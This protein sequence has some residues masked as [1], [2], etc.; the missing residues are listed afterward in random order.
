MNRTRRRVR[1]A[2]PVRR[3]QRIV[4]RFLAL[5]VVAMLIGASGAAALVH[6]G[7]GKIGRSA[8]V[9]LVA[10][11][12]APAR[13][14]DDAPAP[15][16]LNVLIVGNDSREGLTRRQIREFG[17]GRADGNRT[18]TLMLLQLEL[19]GSGRGAVLS[20]P[21]DLLV[22]RCDGTRGRIN[23]ASWIGVARTGDGPSCVVSTVHDLTGVDI[24]HY[25]EVSFAGFLNVVDALGGVGLYLDQPIA[26][27]KAHIDLP[28]GCVRLRGRDALGFVRA[29]YVDDDFGRIARQQRFLKE[30]VRE[31]TDVGVLTN[32]SR[33]LR[34]VDAAAASIRTDDALDVKQM[35]TIA[36]GMRRLTAEGLTVHTVPG[37]AAMSGGT[38][39]V[40]QHDRK[41]RRLYAAFRDGSIVRRHDPPRSRTVKVPVLPPVTVSNAT[42]DPAVAEA[43]AELV[44]AGR[45][46]LAEV[47][48]ADAAGLER[49]RILHDPDHADAAARLARLFPG[50]DV[51]EGVDG[52]ALTVKLGAD[53]RPDQLVRR[54]RGLHAASPEADGK[55]RGA[56]AREP[57]YRGSRMTDVDC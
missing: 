21:R 47:T 22:T 20:F 23:A 17:T 51:I 4:F 56:H 38:W 14:E 28:A 5:F 33:L 11:T 43:A 44:E 46:P 52:L 27:E 8:V 26:D 1:T 10:S 48:A 50:A 35:R 12:N 49:T 53:A 36:M 18:D 2:P 42:V 15:R 7:A 6:W 31:A 41:A 3:R 55:K 9:G 34:V 19:N 30:T 24:H 25:I 54:T 13:A 32:P 40:V 45:F 29:R 37:D 39:Y 57:A 16:L